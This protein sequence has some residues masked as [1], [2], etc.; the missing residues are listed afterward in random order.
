MI[1]RTPKGGKKTSKKKTPGKSEEKSNAQKSEKQVKVVPVTP[2]SKQLEEQRRKEEARKMEEQQKVLMRQRNAVAEKL[3]RVKAAINSSTEQPN[4]N[5]HFLKLQLKTVEACYGEFNAFQNQIY[6]LELTPEQEKQHRACYLKFETLHNSLTIQLNELIERLSKPSAALVAAAPAGAL[7]TQ[8]LPPLSVPLP[9]FDGT[10]ENWFSF[11]CM[12]RS[13]MDRYQG[14]APSM[15]LY[16]LRNSLVGKAEG[17]IDQDIINN[18]DYEAA[19]AL[20]VETYEDKRVIIDKH[21]E[22]LFNLP[23]ITN[24]DAV[25]FRK[26]IDTCVKHIEALKNLQLPVDGLGEQMLMNLLAARMDKETRLAWELQRKAGELPTYAATIAYLKEQCRVLEVVEQCS[27]TVEKV[28]PHRSVAMLIAGTQKCSVCNRQHGL[29]GCEQFKG[30]SVNEKYNHLRKCGLCFNCLRRGHRVAACTSMSTCKI[31]G[32]RHHTMLHTDGV[33]KQMVVPI[34]PAPIAPKSTDKRRPGPARKQTLLSTAVVLVNGRSS[35]PHLCRAL[36]DSGSQHH[37]V[38]ERFANKLAIKKERANY[39]VS[40]LHESQT[41]ISNLV[42][43]TMKSRVSDFSTELELLVT[44]RIV[45]D[46]PPESVDIT[47]WNLPPNIELADPRFNSAGQ[48]DMLLGAGL[49]WN[50]IKSGKITLAE[51]LPSLR[52]TEFGWVV[53]GVLKQSESIR[54]R[55]AN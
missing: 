6:G 33:K 1:L 53:G 45:A 36:I 27:E 22:A 38:T 55:M 43:A 16:H 41:R 12:F 31:C 47:S 35:G 13:V 48:I 3:D 11:K 21:I 49:F 25:A 42:R 7:V 24:D 30:K 18:N 44:P 52:E 39:Q 29:N 17:V 26:L 50:L 46:L 8:Y 4:Q 10:C 2:I 14:E 51:N 40:G 37:F 23:K 34:S 54:A 28:K 9:K 20:L 15:K 19:W 32:K 5:L